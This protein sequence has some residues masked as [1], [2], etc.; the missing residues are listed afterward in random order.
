MIGLD[1]GPATGFV[2]DRE[3]GETQRGIAN[4]LRLGTV[5]EVDYAAAR[6][7]VR[8]GD[9]ADPSATL[10][11]DWLPWQADAGQHRRAWRP[12]AAGQTVMVLAPGGEMAAGLALSA[13]Y[14]DANPA[15]SDNGTVDVVEFGDGARLEYDHA[16]KA[17]RITTPG[18]L[19][20]TFAGDIEVTAPTIRIVGNVEVQGKITSTGDQIA[21][22][23]SQI[24]HVHREVLRGGE[25]SGP[26]Q[27]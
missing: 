25:L 27:V 6:V 8:I 22:G 1:R 2:G 19:A 21:G 20:V 24:G 17:M 3:T 7:R 11:T 15:P 5:E 26:P 4:L 12:L 10:L 16:A 23:V 9:A 14:S 18:T 13:G